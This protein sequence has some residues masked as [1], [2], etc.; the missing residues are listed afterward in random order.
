MPG[1]GFITA[2]SVLG[3]SGDPV[4]LRHVNELAAFVGVVPTE[5]STGDVIRYGGI[6]H[7]GDR[8]LRA[9]LV[10]AAWRAIRY[11]TELEQFYQ[12]IRARHGDK[13]GSQ[14]AIVAVANKLTRMM[15]RVLTDKRLF[16]KH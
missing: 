6:S 10:E 16:V 1:I 12:R 13:G 7:R 11:N 2:T 3:R 14:A 9:L 8:Q 4:L 5:R 15:Y